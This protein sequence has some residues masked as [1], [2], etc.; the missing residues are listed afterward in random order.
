M[1][2]NVCVFDVS[3]AVGIARFESVNSIK[4]RKVIGCTGSDSFEP[5]EGMARGCLISLCFERHC[6]YGARWPVRVSSGP[7]HTT[8]ESKIHT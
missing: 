4:N 7:P 1:F 8:V 6:M 2:R 3:R 5:L